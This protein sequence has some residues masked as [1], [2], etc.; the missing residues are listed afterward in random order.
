MTLLKNNIKTLVILLVI[1]L[2]SFGFHKFYIALTDIDF[3]E[4]EKALQMT[5]TVFIDDLEACINN[6]FNIDCQLN[7]PSEIKKIDDYLHKYLQQHFKVEVNKK[8]RTYNYLGKEYID[9]TV[10]FYLEINKVEKLTSIKIDN[11]MLVK[12]FPDQQNLIKVKMNN[13]RKSLF[14]NKKEHEGTL[15]FK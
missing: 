6:D 9:D 14:L 10:C 11:T 3:N 5:M 7:T 15:F 13:T 2:F 1:P 4:N 8:N 12:Y